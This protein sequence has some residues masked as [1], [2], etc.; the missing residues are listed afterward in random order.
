MIDHQWMEFRDEYGLGYTNLDSK[1]LVL[2]ICYECQSANTE[3]L[4]KAIQ[5]GPLCNSAFIIRKYVTTSIFP[6]LLRG[7]KPK[8]GTD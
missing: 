2:V 1:N 5:K 3:T 8:G 6:L 7:L 4:S